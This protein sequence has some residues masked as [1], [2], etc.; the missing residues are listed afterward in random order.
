MSYR[1]TEKTKARKISQHA[2]LLSSALRIVSKRGFQ[3]LTIA[4]LAEEAEVATGTVYKYFDSKAILCAEVFRIGTEKEVQQ[5]QAAAFPDINKNCKQRLTDAI[6][7]FAQRA[8][9]GHRLAYA[10]IA[11][12][13]SPMI[14]TE[15]LIYRRSYAEI[16]TALIKEGIE[17]QEFCPQDA[18]IS[19]AAIVGTLAETLAGPLAP[20]APSQSESEQQVLVNNIQSFCL[21]AVS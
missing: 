10:L 18:H 15:R 21:R 8:I 14:E 3:A 20:H 4:A 2:L 12:P 6:Y 16:F 19:A 9:E 7:I 11:E 17:K 13:V 1:P 5:V